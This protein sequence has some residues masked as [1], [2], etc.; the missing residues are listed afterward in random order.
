MPSDEKPTRLR[1]DRVQGRDRFVELESRPPLKWLPVRDGNAAVVFLSGY[2]GGAVAGDVPAIDIQVGA[3]S[4][5]WVGSQAHTRV[6]RNPLAARTGQFLTGLLEEGAFC[7]HLPDPVTPQRDSS[8]RQS[9]RWTLHADSTL[10]VLES[11]CA[12]R[13]GYEP[14][15]SFTR[16]E[17][18]LEVDD[19]SG[20]PLLRE[21]YASEPERLQPQ[22]AGAFGSYTR[23]WNLFVCSPDPGATMDALVSELDAAFEPFS[24]VRE[25]LAL[26]FG[27]SR[28]EVWC[29]RALAKSASSLEPLGLALRQ[30][31]SE[32]SRIGTDPLAR[33]P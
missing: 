14:D 5:L 1:V 23:L 28:P 29:A 6:Y 30:I 15:F 25:D 17:S 26:S 9:S 21:S 24:G 4:R 12:G 20:R 33:R 11:H 31:L 3:G 8:W 13:E 7:A 22:S 32:D 19:A 27:R 10:V 2:G 18:R 16:F